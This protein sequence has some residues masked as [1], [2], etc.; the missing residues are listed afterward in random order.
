MKQFAS[1]FIVG[2]VTGVVFRESIMTRLRVAVNTADEKLDEV[3][4]QESNNDKATVR[5]P[6]IGTSFSPE[7]KL[8][9]NNST[10]ENPVVVTWDEIAEM[11]LNYVKV[12]IGSGRFQ[13]EEVEK[14]A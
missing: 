10:P 13:L 2:V 8:E 4:E 7:R 12:N 5:W 14:A 6:A 3:E 1:G 11:N 9:I